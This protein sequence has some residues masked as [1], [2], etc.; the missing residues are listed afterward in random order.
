MARDERVACYARLRI[1]LAWQ[2]KVGTNLNPALIAEEIRRA[3]CSDPSFFGGKE[4]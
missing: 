1:E 4:I 2:M 3:V